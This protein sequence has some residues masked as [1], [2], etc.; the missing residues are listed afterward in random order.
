MNYSLV[1]GAL[2]DGDLV[3]A[4]KNNALKERGLQCLSLAYIAEV[5]QRLI[6]ARLGFPSLFQYLVQEL[7]FSEA[8]SLKRIQVSRLAERFP[9]V[10]SLLETG[11]VSMTVLQKLA[12]HLLVSNHRVLLNE[13]TGK[14]VRDVERMLAARFP[15]AIPTHPKEV[16]TP[17][18]ETRIS[19]SFIA[20]KEF[21]L[22]LQDSKAFLSH[23]Y[24]DGN[25]VDIFREGLKLL[26][27]GRPK[28][29]QGA[30]RI[31]A[32]SVVE[33]TAA[34]SAKM[35]NQTRYIPAKI[36][37]VVWERDRGR[38]SFVS[39]GGR[40]CES[41][42]FLEWDHV[43]PFS[44]G[45]RGDDPDNIRILCRSHNRLMAHDFFGRPFVEEKIRARSRSAKEGDLDMNRFMLGIWTAGGLT[46][47]KKKE[48]AVAS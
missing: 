39:S 31:L 9:V 25:L 2:G 19:L 4:L 37:E 44:T 14:S 11:K 10:Y 45:G 6:Y 17:L 16:I 13:S 21:E 43:I 34:M 18:D 3:T 15:E 29:L 8:T 42:Y 7:G 5:E 28:V 47:L 36:K 33:K 48:W 40:A 30:P 26:L 23:K 24:P 20:D 22:L 38:C 35:K 12:P 1:A 46:R 32:D 27:S 41:N